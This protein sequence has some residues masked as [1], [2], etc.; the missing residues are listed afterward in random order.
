MVSHPSSR[1]AKDVGFRELSQQY[2][3]VANPSHPCGLHLGYDVGTVSAKALRPKG[4]SPHEPLPRK[5]RDLHPFIIHIP[6]RLS[7]DLSILGML[8]FWLVA[9]FLHA[10]EWMKRFDPKTCAELRSIFPSSICQVFI[11][12]SP[13]DPNGPM[14]VIFVDFRAQFR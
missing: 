4:C 13:K 6:N 11:L 3:E 2:L 10:L 12:W 8:I 5:V 1:G 7:L 9:G 14:K